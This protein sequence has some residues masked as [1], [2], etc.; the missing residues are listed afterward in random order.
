LKLWRSFE[1][2]RLVSLKLETKL[3]KS[4][5]TVRQPRSG[6]VPKMRYRRPRWSQ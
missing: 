5:E 6:T 1:N 3:M 2:A 4:D